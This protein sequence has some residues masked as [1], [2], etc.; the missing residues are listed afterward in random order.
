MLSTRPQISV[1]FSVPLFL[2]ALTLGLPRVSHALPTSNPLPGITGLGTIPTAD[3]V[4]PGVPEV[5]LNYERVDLDDGK[6]DLLPVASVIYGL[7]KGEVGAT[8]VRESS[9]AQGI[10]FRQS[11]YALQGKVRLLERPNAAIALGAHYYDF[12]SDRGVDLGHVLSGYLAASVTFRRRPPGQV[13]AGEARARAHGGLLV[14]RVRGG[15]TSDTLVRPF[16]GAEY[17]LTREVSLAADYLTSDREAARAFT[18]SVRYVPPQFPLS[19][20]IGVGK[21]R[22]DTKFFV[23]LSYQ[24]GRSGRRSPSQ[25]TPAAP[26]QGGQL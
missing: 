2:G 14:Q 25:T 19:A 8:Y 1:V 12:G 20:Q 16:I 3:S 21:L 17:G 23:G 18:V 5:S 22:S 6:V 4:A 10:S 11:Y 26:M 9:E 24:F 15:G 7:G 13:G